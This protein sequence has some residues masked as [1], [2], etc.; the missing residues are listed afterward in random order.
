MQH[1]VKENEKKQTESPIEKEDEVCGI[2]FTGIHPSDNPRGRLNSCNH[3]FCAYCIKEWAQSTNVCPHCKAR[4]TRIFVLNNN[5]EEEVTKVRKRNYK[6]WEEDDEDENEDGENEEENSGEASHSLLVACDVCGQGDN[7]FRMIFC[8]RR[9]CQYAVHLDC[10]HL[11]ERPAE[12]YCSQCAQLRGSTTATTPIATTT[13]D[14]DIEIRES[15]QEQEMREG[16]NLSSAVESQTDA[17]PPCKTPY[18]KVSV[19]LPTFLRQAM[20]RGI[21]GQTTVPQ[22]GEYQDKEISLTSS[23]SSQNRGRGRGGDQELHIIQEDDMITRSSQAALQ[24]Y[25]KRQD[26]QNHQIRLQQQ[27]QHHHHHHHNRRGEIPQIRDMSKRGVGV[28]GIQPSFK[29]PRSYNNTSVHHTSVDGLLD[30]TTRRKEE[31]RLARQLAIEMLP[32]LRRNQ[33]IQESQLQFGRNG[34]IVVS[35]VPNGSD[36]TVRERELYVK[37]MTEARRMAQQQIEAK[38]VKARMRMERQVRIQAQREAAALAKLA[39]IVASHRV[40]SKPN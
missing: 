37:A 2:C 29:R 28:V 5:G 15:I 18:S 7:A 3:I 39:K 25:L 10:I 27:Q 13:N 30:P 40:A 4:F 8:D 26:N 21:R 24:E 22:Q 17:V 23:S 11:N 1:D 9:Q 31:D 12:F 38:V 19:A 20:E 36:A 16:R 6:R 33:Q 35:A 14:E 32:I 34:D